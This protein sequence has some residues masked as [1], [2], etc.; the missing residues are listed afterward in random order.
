MQ[1]SGGKVIVT[2]VRNFAFIFILMFVISGCSDRR[3]SDGK[4]SILPVI[5]FE[6]EGAGSSPI[7][8]ASKDYIFISDMLDGIVNVYN[9][10]GNKIKTF[11]SKGKGPGEFLSVSMLCR[12]EPLDELVIYDV[13][14]KRLSF[15]NKEFELSN[16]V[17]IQE[18]LLSIQPLQNNLLY[19]TRKPA[20]NGMM[21]GFNDLVTMKNISSDE[22][23]ITKKF[24]PASDDVLT[25][26]DKGLLIDTNSE[27]L[28]VLN[29]GDD[30]VIEQYVNGT[31]KKIWKLNKE[32]INIEFTKLNSIHCGSNFIILN[33]VKADNSMNYAFFDFDEQFLGELNMNTENEYIIDVHKNKLIKLVTDENGDY[34]CSIMEVKF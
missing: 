11:G 7:V 17:N 6:I 4:L 18:Y 25:Y 15:F 1:Y 23:I 29:R 13:Y 16:T 9:Y 31:N 19:V 33:L 14:Q 26:V 3:N 20:E 10:E 28:F 8:H 27:N 5:S 21:S 2:V 30:F 22:K 12:L 34:I 24:L 32:K